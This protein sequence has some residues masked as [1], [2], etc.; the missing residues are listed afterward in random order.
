MIISQ[1]KVIL[2]LAS[3][4]DM[5]VAYKP[6]ALS[7]LN[8]PVELQYDFFLYTFLSLSFT[9]IGEAAHAETTSRQSLIHILPIISIP[10]PHF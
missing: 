8:V 7:S 2:W 1:S 5:S 3:W 4:Q 9:P 10:G 6:D